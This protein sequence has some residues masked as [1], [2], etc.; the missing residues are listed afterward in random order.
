MS[1][2]PDPLVARLRSSE[3][4]PLLDRLEKKLSQGEGLSGRIRLSALTETQS[5]R[6]KE[7]TG[8]GSRGR[9][10]TVDLDAFTEIV[11]NT[12]RFQSLRQAVEVALGYP[13]E[14]RRAKRIQVSQDWQSAWERAAE[15]IHTM[16]FAANTS[17]DS[18]SNNVSVVG[19]VGARRLSE[20]S[21]IQK[22][23]LLN[24]LAD[25]RKGWLVRVTNRDAN[26]AFELIQ[27]AIGVLKV[28]PVEPVPLPIFS[29]ERTGDAHGLDNHRT[30]GKLCLR[31]LASCWRDERPDLKRAL[32]RR[33][34]WESVGVVTDEL[35]ASVLA[36]NLP[37]V[38]ES[39]TDRMI[40]QHKSAGMPCRLTFRHLRLHP[41]QFANVTKE[42]PLFVCENPSVI[43][44]AADRL[45]QWCPPMVCVEGM[46]NLTCWSVLRRLDRCGFRI[47][48]HGDFDWGGIR[49]ANKLFEAFAFQ[50]WRFSSTDHRVISTSHRRL[51][52][53]RAEAL[54]DSQL[55]EKIQNS[56]VSV[57]E[58][59]VIASLLS[60]L[61]AASR[62]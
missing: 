23:S 33:R 40:Q 1:S 16:E 3:C 20:E 4:R 50:P 11:C 27:K 31:F 48:Y 21:L 61:D 46:P 49:I 39:L 29:A 24:C 43:A 37:A 15:L 5:R 25:L 6:I 52:P 13:V 60:D 54:W 55:S 56:C 41:P 34:V 10:V 19:N 18:I 42:T 58:E 7:L 53:P 2:P 45:T 57:E 22:E 51:K 26:A 62:S 14:N 35:S 38:G 9:A 44:A 30:L 47:N 36:L 59:S 28:L 8:S 17:G 12:G 32:W